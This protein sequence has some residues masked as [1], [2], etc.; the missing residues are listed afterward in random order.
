MYNYVDEKV[1]D[2][3]NKKFQNIRYMETSHCDGLDCYGILFTTKNG[4]V[5]YSGDT[6]EI[7]NV[8]K[9]IT[10]GEQ[11]DKLYI[12]TTTANFLGNAH[13]YIGILQQIIPE[14][15][16]KCVYWCI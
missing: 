11:I 12:D 10:S 14:K 6:R 5:Y 2:G 4:I 13:L 8:K 15:L 16:K 1:Y 3:K 7:N 9:I